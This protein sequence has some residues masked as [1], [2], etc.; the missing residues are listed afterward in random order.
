M[1]ILILPD[2]SHPA[3]DSCLLL[4]ES[5]AKTL[6]LRHH[7]VACC[8][9]QKQAFSDRTRFP[10]PSQ[11]VH[12]FSKTYVQK[13]TIEEDYWNLGATKY[14]FLKE[15]LTAIA[16]AVHSFEP[17]LIID[18]G[19]IA[20][21]I[22]AALT[23]VPCWSFI[24]A[25]SF[26]NRRFDAKCLSGVNRLLTEVK[27][28]QILRLTD[29]YHHC[30]TLFT[31]GTAASQPFTDHPGLR[32]YGSMF[33][34]LTPTTGKD[35][36][37]FLAETSIHPHRLLTMTRKAFAGAGYNVKIYLPNIKAHTEGNLIFVDHVDEHFMDGARACV[38]DGNLW[39]YNLAST[40][41][42]P[43]CIIANNGWQRS[44][45]ATAVQ[46]MG[47]G[48]ARLDLDLSMELLYESYRVILSH[49]RFR[50]NALLQEVSLLKMP[51]ITQMTMDIEASLH[52]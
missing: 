29:L 50:D 21:P 44:R 5:I 9:P 52:R 10:S 49:D 11:P 35:L 12:L 15:D 24:T 47:I 8:L 18:C 40:L 43:Q 45:T 16:N 37:I 27:V 14:R 7:T 42:I 41:A 19:R 4:A 6:S 34:E 38:S 2:T 26:K 48:T 30:S 1:K 23:N 31:F 51:D 20:A 22:A 17:D 32:R 3:E 28:E 13:P 25:A 46:R 39:I 36:C 33:H